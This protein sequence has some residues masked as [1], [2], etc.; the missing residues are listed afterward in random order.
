MPDKL[1][2]YGVYEIRV[3]PVEM[4]G[5]RWDAEYEIRHNSKAVQPWTSV[6]GDAGLPSAAEAIEFAHRRAVTDIEAGAGI[7]KPRVF[8]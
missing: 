5:S 8:P 4:Q 7:P 6:G 1:F 3:R 2:L